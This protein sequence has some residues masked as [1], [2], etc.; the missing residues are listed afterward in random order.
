MGD[1]GLM[2]DA[3]KKP[4]WEII[5]MAIDILKYEMNTSRISRAM[6]VSRSS[7]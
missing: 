4:T 3:L 1:Q 5:G 6:S 2:I 7:I